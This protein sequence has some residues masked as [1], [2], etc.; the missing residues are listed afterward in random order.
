M[1]CERCGA[2]SD[3]YQLHDYCS[4]CGKNLCED[5]MEQGCCG[6]VPAIS[7]MKD[8]EAVEA[9]EQAVGEALEDKDF[10]RDSSRPNTEGQQGENGQ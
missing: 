6:N 4:E 10:T 3:G 1:E 7:G 8:A 9:A 5:C 2:R